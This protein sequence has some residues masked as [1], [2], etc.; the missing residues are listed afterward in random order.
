[1]K[2]KINSVNWGTRPTKEGLQQ[3]ESKAPEIKLDRSYKLYF[4]AKQNLSVAEKSKVLE[5]YAHNNNTRV[6]LLYRDTV[7]FTFGLADAK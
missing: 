6:T 4:G 2:H 3:K 5:A 7:A 1:M